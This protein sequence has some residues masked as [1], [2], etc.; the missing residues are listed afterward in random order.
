M[1]LE[2]HHSLAI[3]VFLEHLVLLG[4]ILLEHLVSLE[5]P[6]VRLVLRV[7]SFLVL[8]AVL[9][10]LELLEGQQLQEFSLQYFHCRSIQS[11]VQ[12]RHQH[13]HQQC[14]HQFQYSILL[15]VVVFRSVLVLPNEQQCQPIHPLLCCYEEFFDYKYVYLQLHP[16]L[17]LFIFKHPL[18]SNLLEFH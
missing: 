8:P 13:K 6:A 5:H 7:R 17:F 4:L 16:F 15:V 10:H 1:V 9:E 14:L 3:L 18:L 11:S 2:H 12:V